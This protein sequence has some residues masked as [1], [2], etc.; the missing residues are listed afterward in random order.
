MSVTLTHPFLA[1]IAITCT[2]LLSQSLYRIYLHP[3]SH[4]PGPLIAK[5]SSLWLW[6]HAYVGDEASVI[7][8]LHARYGA[9]VRVSPNEVDISDHEAVP[10]IYV[11]KGGFPKAECYANF[12][13]DGHK[14]IFSTVDVDYRTPRA[15]AVV[16]LFSTKSLRENE[17]ALYECVDRMVSRMKAEKEA[18]GIVNV[19]N[20]ARSLA[21]DAVSTHLFNENYN[22]TSEKSSRLSASAFVDAFVA[23]GRFF[24]LPNILFVWVDW[25]VAKIFPDEHTDASM[26]VVDRFV[27]DLV[28]K[29]PSRGAS[30]YPGRLMELDLLEKSEVKAQCKDLLFAGTDSTGMNLSTICRQLALHPEKYVGS[31]FKLL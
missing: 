23:V 6:Y 18:R 10:A 24:Y 19:L 30:N 4:I 20:L 2:L 16:P 17:A 8:A 26:A 11:S 25:A 15:K 3:I 28:D 31:P 21:V 27:E 22:G 29:T 14:T 9:L 12:D 1:L 7:H 13:I 5:V